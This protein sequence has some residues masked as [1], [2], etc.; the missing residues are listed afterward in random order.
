MYYDFH[1]C[2]HGHSIENCK[3]LKYNVQALIKGGY[4]NFLNEPNPNVI[5]NP[6]PNHVEPNVNVIIKE[7]SRKIKTNVEELKTPMMVIYEALV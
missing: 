5:D 7:Q 2:A 4:L 3:A 6:W 1:F